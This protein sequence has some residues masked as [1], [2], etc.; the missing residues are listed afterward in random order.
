MRALGYIRVSTAEQANTG[1]SLAVQRDR[2]DAWCIAR[3][4]E[5]VDVV[6]DEGV[7][8][9]KALERRKGGAELLRR[10]AAGEAEVVVVVSI[11]RIFR[12]AQDGLN[13]LLGADGKG[14]MALQSVTDPV[15]TTTAM[16][17]FIL[18]VWLARAQLERE[19]TCERN[20]AV[21]RSLRQQGR[22][23]GHTPYGCVAEAGR[24]YHD[25]ATWPTRADIVDARR[26]GMTLQAIS[27]ELAERGIPAPS[28]GATWSKSVLNELIKS[29]HSLVHLPLWNKP[30]APA[31][32]TPEA[33]VSTAPTVD[34]SAIMIEESATC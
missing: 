14:G 26:R 16:G 29:H 32:P 21:S 19:Q 33:R 25:P 31:A 11:D 9:G 10:M 30:A 34:V 27:D 23:N 12:D 6:L 8:A 22:P 28:G 24:L 3:D 20:L 13:T 2:I 7:S 5:L 4:L 15:D 17:R 18:T 1:H